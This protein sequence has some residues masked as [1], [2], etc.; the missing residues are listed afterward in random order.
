MI[1]ILDLDGEKV[2]NDTLQ[3]RMF[4]NLRDYCESS[5]RNENSAWC[6]EKNSRE[7]R[8]NDALHDNR[9]TNVRA[10]IT[11]NW[12][13]KCDPVPDVIFDDA[14]EVVVI[15]AAP[16]VRVL[17]VPVIPTL[18]IAQQHYENIVL[19]LDRWAEWTR[20]GGVLAD[21]APTQ[22]MMAPDARIHSFED[23]EI[24]VD[25]RLVGEMNTAVWELS[26]IEREAVM[27][28][29]GLNTRS[30]WRAQFVLVFD[31][32]IESLFRTLKTRISC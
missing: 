4:P 17:V 7:A 26:V 28:H 27:T 13:G 14:P 21:G 10:T 30:V 3:T 6:G 15:S 16:P 18:S 22:S 24:E 23:M 11:R 19:L 9:S 31:Q 25:K 8:G 29:Y 5:V 20:V 32:A 12:G 1:G 2:A